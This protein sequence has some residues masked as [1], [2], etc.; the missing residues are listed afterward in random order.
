MVRRTI[1]LGMMT[2]SAIAL[3]LA[4]VTVTNPDVLTGRLASV[5]RVMKG[6]STA[7]KKAV[8]TSSAASASVAPKIT[9]FG[10]DALPYTDARNQL[11][12]VMG[13]VS[14]VFDV[15]QKNYYKDGLTKAMEALKWDQISEVRVY[16]SATRNQI[17]L[18][19]RALGLNGKFSYTG[20]DGKTTASVYYRIKMRP[21]D[22]SAPQSTML[23]RPSSCASTAPQE[24]YVFSAAV[25]D[26][27]NAGS[28]TAP[29]PAG[30]NVTIGSFIVRGQRG[31]PNLLLQLRSLTFTAAMSSAVK[32]ANVRLRADGT[33]EK[34]ECIL[35]GLPTIVCDSIPESVGLMQ[36]DKRFTV[37]A[38][39][40][41]VGKSAQ[42]QLR[43][44]DFGSINA[45][46]PGAVR[47][48]ND[49]GNYDWITPTKDIVL[50]TMYK[51]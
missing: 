26:I 7:P 29:F 27:V 39:V 36:G 50:G 18:A 10:V 19:V 41:R 9:T 42:L 51:D 21:Y 4:L 38:D 6:P 43:L 34:G 16:D 33:D 11:T 22:R 35:S 48:K 31:D 28:E 30:N 25:T 5:R 13:N 17:G 14:Q 3:V 8:K 20:D 23:N 44:S 49:V 12:V 37:T 2:A 46:V 47:W 1:V 40:T 32:L 45:S 24:V 15:C